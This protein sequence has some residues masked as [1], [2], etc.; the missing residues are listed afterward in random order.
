MDFK[1]FE[2]ACLRDLST[3]PQIYMY[4]R[5]VDFRKSING[6]SE[7]VESELKLVPFSGA[8]FVFMGRHKDRIKILYWDKSG[9]ALWYKILEEARFCWLKRVDEEVIMLTPE[10]LEW[11]LSGIDIWKIKVHR[12]LSFEKIG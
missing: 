9:F 2:G 7:I 6:L 5:F 12:E 4:R 11:L 10:R 3:F 1:V 8:L